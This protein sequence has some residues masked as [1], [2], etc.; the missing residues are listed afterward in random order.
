MALAVSP[1]QIRTDGV[2]SNQA[3]GVR[4]SGIGLVGPYDR[5]GGFAR[6]S[7]TNVPRQGTARNGRA[8]PIVELVRNAGTGDDPTS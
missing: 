2:V 7:M 3:V 1:G 4:V 6:R 5:T 8:T